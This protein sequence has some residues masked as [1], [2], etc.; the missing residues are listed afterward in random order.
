MRT[1]ALGQRSRVRSGTERG[2]LLE[3][4]IAVL[5]VFKQGCKQI[6]TADNAASSLFARGRLEAWIVSMERPHS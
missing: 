6:R 5:G 2:K 4:S 1:G 3:N